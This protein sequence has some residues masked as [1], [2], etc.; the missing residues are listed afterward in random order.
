MTA[1]HVRERGAALFP[2]D[3]AG[4]RVE[5]R[6][7][8]DGEADEEHRLEVGQPPE[9]QLGH[10]DAD[11]LAEDRVGGAVDHTGE[12]EDHGGSGGR[13]SLPHEHAGDE[14]EDHEKPLDVAGADRFA[15]F[16]IADAPRYLERADDPAEDREVADAPG[17]RDQHAEAFE[18]EPAQVP[19]EDEGGRRG[20][21]GPAPPEV[22]QEGGKPA[23]GE[24]DPDDGRQQEG[25]P[26]APGRHRVRPGRPGWPA[27]R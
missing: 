1:R 23:A 19:L 16:E 8:A 4:Q 15:D 20:G 18:G 6:H 14:A 7:A 11:V 2:L 9:R 17:G 10:V 3:A 22:A 21:N 13:E 24:E 25:D 5:H 12:G 27:S 26:P